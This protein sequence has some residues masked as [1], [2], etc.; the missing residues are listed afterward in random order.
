MLLKGVFVGHLAHLMVKTMFKLRY[1][2]ELL[3]RAFR[4]VEAVNLRN[5][6]LDHPY[7]HNRRSPGARLVSPPARKLPCARPAKFSGPP[8]Y[9]Y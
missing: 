3:S 8:Q 1:G 5:T 9:A 6:D 2:A 4:V 7:T